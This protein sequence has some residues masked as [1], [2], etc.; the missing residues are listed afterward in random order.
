[1][2]IRFAYQ[3]SI[4][5]PREYEFHENLSLETCM[6][7]FLSED[8]LFINDCRRVFIV[9]SNYK[10]KKILKDTNLLIKEVSLQADEY[11]VLHMVYRG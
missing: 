5:Y 11:F 3:I 7:I 6:K 4:K 9:D 10:I 2:K 1:M 8:N